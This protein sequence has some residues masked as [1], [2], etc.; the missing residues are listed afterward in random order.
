MKERPMLMS[1]PLIVATLN[2]TKTQTRRLPTSATALV[3]GNRVSPKAWKLF[4]WDWDTAVIDGTRIHVRESGRPLWHD[5]TPIWNVREQLWLREKFGYWHGVRAPDAIVYGAAFDPEKDDYEN[6]E[7]KPSIHM[8][9]WASRI[10]LK[11]TAVRAERLNSISEQ[12]AKA[13]GVF[14]GFEYPYENGEIDCPACHGE[15]LYIQGSMGGASEVDCDVCGTLKARFRNLWDSI[16][17]KRGWAWATNRP[18]FVL[19]YKRIRP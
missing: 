8:P 18:V 12:D 15:G 10:D 16:N 19:T 7:W 5:L 14:A 17:G 13:E 1:G 6:A 11:I 4:A 2:D 9:R 3:D